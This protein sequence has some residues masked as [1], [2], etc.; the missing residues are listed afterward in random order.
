M[1]RKISA[2][3][4]AMGIASAVPAQSIDIPAGPLL[5]RG[6]VDA[7][8]FMIGETERLAAG[9]ITA[10][11]DRSVAE[12]ASTHSIFQLMD[13]LYISTPGGRAPSVGDLF[14]SLARGPRVRGVGRVIVP[15]GILQV[16]RVDRGFYRVRIVKQFGEITLDQQVI[17]YSAPTST[18]TSLTAVTPDS[19][20]TGR[21]VALHGRPVLPSLQH[22]LFVQMPGTAGL[23][24]GDEVILVDNQRR[25]DAHRP[26]PPEI[27]G[28][29]RVMKVTPAA[30][31]VI[32]VAVSQ[33]AIRVGTWAMRVAEAR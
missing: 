8:P 33:P 9:R 23:R 28:R 26:M 11:A 25:R 21:V 22:Y 6:E 12:R 24:P 20:A 5:L 3:L 30:A 32:I 31:T 10:T 27:V 18:P 2:W 13:E 4:V 29:A 1:H 15:S 17:S 16:I 19:S 7:A 14:F